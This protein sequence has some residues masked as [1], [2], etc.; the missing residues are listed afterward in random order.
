[1]AA[2][3]TGLIAIAAAPLIAQ[4]QVADKAA[5]WTAR[6]TASGVLSSNTFNYTTVDELKAASNG[7]YSSNLPQ[8][9][10]GLEP[11]INLTGRNALKVTT[12]ASAT[13]NGGT[14]QEWLDGT[15]G[16]RYDK[17]YIQFAVYFPRDTLAY[18]WQ[19]G[20]GQLKVLNIERYGAGQV[21][22]TNPKFLGFPSI[23][24]NGLTGMSRQFPSPP[25]PNVSTEYTYQPA[26]DTGS[27]A[28]PGNS[29]EF[30]SR[31]GAA[32]GIT[33][34]ENYGYDASKPY[35]DQ[36]GLPGGFPNRCALNA[37]VPYAMNDWTV[38]EVFVDTSNP[39][40]SVNTV[41]SWAAK[42]GNAPRL[43]INEIGT[44]K[45]QRSSDYY[46]RFELMN[47]DTPREA[48]SGRP[49]LYT[50]FDE[51]IVST[52]PIKFPGGYSLPDSN[53]P[54]PNPPTSV[55]AE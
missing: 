48:E 31:Y 46:R 12:Y 39:D 29:C 51:V 33:V 25:V 41:R 54:R 52:A 30:W 43:T 21:T 14:W 28:N 8:N 38:I 9:E 24:L 32:R 23:M 42:Y 53:G 22:V 36:R 44:A 17:F 16:N 13:G 7:T 35:L 19:G 18:R 3:A 50:Y 20:D 26:I 55:H 15:T 5:D 34:N 27:P 2:V 11:T 45:I 40:S 1:M 6:S 4:A 49:T 47:Y 10:I 37:G